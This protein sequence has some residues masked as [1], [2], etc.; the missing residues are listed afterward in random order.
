MLIAVGKA[1]CTNARPTSAGLK[2]FCPSP[3]NSDLPSQI[4]AK[5]A[6]APIHSGNEGG[7]VSASNTPVMVA[8]QSDSEL[9]V[10][11]MRLL[12]RSATRQASGDDQYQRRGGQAVLPYGKDAD[13]QQREHHVAHDDGH[14]APAVL[15][16]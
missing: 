14:I 11:E 9:G 12:M 13:R 15:V 6:T 8:L 2:G 10:P 3:P 7:S 4:A 16:R 1:A 5:P